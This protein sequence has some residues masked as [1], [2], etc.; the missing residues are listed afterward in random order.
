M[1][2][3]K[4]LWH[5]APEVHLNIVTLNMNT[6]NFVVALISMFWVFQSHHMVRECCATPWPALSSWRT[7]HWGLMLEF[8]LLSH[9]PSMIQPDNCR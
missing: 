2:K 1:N 4:A 5:L 6:L 8:P 9:C 3:S 7:Q